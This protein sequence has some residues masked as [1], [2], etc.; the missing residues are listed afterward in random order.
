MTA[1]LDGTIAL[2]DT[3]GV[4]T[5]LQR[6]EA[7][8]SGEDEESSRSRQAGA[9]PLTLLARMKLSKKNNAETLSFNEVSRGNEAQNLK[10]MDNK[11][12]CLRWQSIH[13]KDV[14]YLH[15]LNPKGI[16]CA[17]LHP[18][19]PILMTTGSKAE[20]IIRSYDR[21]TRQLGEVVSSIPAD[22]ANRT[23]KTGHSQESSNGSK[24][25]DFG[26]CLLVH[27]SGKMVALGTVEG[28]VHL[29]QIEEKKHLVS[30]K[31]SGQ[32]VKCLHFTPNDELLVGGN[33]GYVSVFD[34]QQY[35]PKSSSRVPE[36]EDEDLFDDLD[37][38]ADDFTHSQHSIHTMSQTSS[39]SS[40]F[41]QTQP[42][43][44]TSLKPV[45]R[46]SSHSRWLTGV[47]ASSDGRIV[48]TR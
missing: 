23:E 11:S 1:A 37:E 22:D 15:T 35:V 44:S 20:L 34:V 36:T 29:F 41:S 43:R 5:S 39:F 13:Q 33:D 40:I 7:N 31:A 47:K 17:V 2:W 42:T 18:T 24:V 30:I 46:W 25:K 3:S 28:F 10:A 16:Y 32:A 45:R 9:F 14:K 21:D 38:F 12:E 48:A 26:L 27:D 8:P 6:S 4:S 19:E